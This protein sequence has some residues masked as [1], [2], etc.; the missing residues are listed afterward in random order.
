M[1]D[2]KHK[3]LDPR[4][5]EVIKAEMDRKREAEE[6]GDMMRALARTRDRSRN[7][8][9]AAAFL[10]Q[11]MRGGGVDTVQTNMGWWTADTGGIESIL[12]LMSE[13]LALGE[14]AETRELDR[15]ERLL[16]DRISAAV[17]QE[18]SDAE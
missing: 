8:S 17:P 14:E 9:R 2:C 18:P 7:A 12:D 1:T 4:P 13:A 15:L 6:A 16:S 3:G 5:I 11:H 10:A